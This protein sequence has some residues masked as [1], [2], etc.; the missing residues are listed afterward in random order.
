MFAYE[1][2]LGV[3]LVFSLAFYIVAKGSTDRFLDGE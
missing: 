3:S 1:I 2:L